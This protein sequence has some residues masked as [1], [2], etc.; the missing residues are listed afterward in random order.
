MNLAVASYITPFGSDC[1]VA[2]TNAEVVQQLPPLTDAFLEEVFGIDNPNVDNF[3]EAATWLWV[4][5]EDGI[6]MIEV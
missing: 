4:G 5:P 2:R 1:L 3:V 6:P